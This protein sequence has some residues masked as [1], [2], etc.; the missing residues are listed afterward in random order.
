MGQM[1]QQ[2]A[3]T[4]GSI[5]G[6]A[7]GAPLG[8]PPSLGASI[9]GQAGGALG[10]IAGG[11]PHPI[12]LPQAQPWQ[13]NRTPISPVNMAPQDASFSDLLKLITQMRG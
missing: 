3:P 7:A 4:A 8:I 9:G 2:L 11:S 5:G 6:A 10:S 12:Q 1:L 13:P